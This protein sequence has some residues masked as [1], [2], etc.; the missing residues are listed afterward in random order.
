MKMKKILAMILCVAMVLSTIGTVAFAEEADVWGGTSYSLEW[1]STGDPEKT[2][3]DKFYLNSAEDLA[4]LAYYVNT[5]ASTNNIFTGDTVYLNVDVDLDNHDWA[6][7]GTA[8][9]R[10]KNRF[11]GSFDGQGHTISNLK[12]GEGHYYAGLFGQI[13]TYDYTQTF[14]NITIENA[15]V[16]AE[17]ETETGKNKE[18]AGTLI[19]RANGTIVENCHVTGEINI[20]GDRFVGGLIGHSYAQIS[21]CSVESSGTISADTWQAGGLV[22]S[23]GATATYTSSIKN[24]SVIGNGDD[25]LSVTSYYKSVGGVIGSVSLTDV[26]STPMDGITVANVSVAADSEDYGSGIAYVAVGYAATNSTTD[27]VSA[28]LGNEEYVADDADNVEAAVAKI[29]N[30]YYATLK[31][32]IDSAVA[33]DTIYL[34]G[35]INEGAIKLPATITNLTIDGQETAVVKDTTIN[36][37]DGNSVNYQG[38]TIKNTTFDNSRFVL[39]GVRNGDVI[40]K[41][42]VFDNN[43]FINI[44]NTAS[45]AAIHMNLASED[46]EYIENFTFTNN[47]IDGVT[48]SNN[49]GV[50]LKSITGNVLFEGNTVSNVAWNAIQ[51]ATA[52]ADANLVI[53]NNSFTSSGSSVLNIA[54]APKATL[55]NNTVVNESGKTGIY[56]PA[57]AKT[58]NTYYKTLEEALKAITNE[59]NVVDILDTI[60]IDYKWDNRNTGA[61]ITVPVTING[62]DNIIKVTGEISDGFNYLSVFRFEDDATVRDLT[63]DLSEAIS[64]WSPRLRAISAKGNLTVD[65]CTFIGNK[66]YTNTRAIIFGESGSAPF[67]ADAQISIT[68][69]EFIDWRKGITDNENAKD[70]KTVTVTGNKFTNASVGISATDTIE[71]NN[72]TVTGGNVTITSYTIPNKLSVVAK[73][74]TLDETLVN[75]IKADAIDADSDF[76]LP[77]ADINGE[78]YWTITEAMDAA[79]KNDVIKITN[80]EDAKINE[81]TKVDDETFKTGET[82]VITTD[83]DEGIEVTVPELVSHVLESYDGTQGTY[84]VVVEHKNTAYNEAAATLDLDISLKHTYDGVTKDVDVADGTTFTVK[85]KLPENA[86]TTKPITILH[87]GE[88]ITEYKIE[89]KCVVFETDGFSPF[90]IGYQLLSVN[91]PATMC[92]KAEVK[93]VVSEENENNT[94]YDIV[95]KSTDTKDI[96]GLVSA[97]MDITAAEMSGVNFLVEGANDFI[98]TNDADSYLFTLKS[99]SNQALADTKSGESVT[100]GKLTISGFT[101]DP[102]KWTVG[103]YTVNSVINTDDGAATSYLDTNVTP[104][105][106][107]NIHIALTGGSVT[108]EKDVPKQ[109]LTVE[110]TF[111]KAIEDNDFN[112]QD[113][114]ITVSEQDYGIVKEFVLGKNH[115]DNATITDD[116]YTVSVNLPK[117]KTYTV[118]IE[119]AGYRTFTKTVDLDADK[120]MIVWNNYKDNGALII[121]DGETEPEAK[122][123]IT[124]LAGDIVKDNTVNAYDLSVLLSYAF[125]EGINTNA[126]SKYAQYDLNRDGLINYKDAAMILDAKVWGK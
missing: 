28:T 95:I 62:N 45:M 31:A 65:N 70:V 29:D 39:G 51:I 126:A 13:P 109:E 98:V 8:V 80:N 117:Y 22:G 52:K 113:M 46:N 55:E 18:A 94:V 81:I 34:I 14:S 107:K 74:N 125:T 71:F 25:G 30:K 67:E 79:E 111:P 23:H 41:D 40:Y 116:K 26:D 77:A 48:G 10:E 122:A 91:A 58:G 63:I 36:A 92:E 24:C 32:A 86:D 88:L 33:G 17:N 124:F 3:G 82:E 6:P 57:K 9:P 78:K 53:K 7:I 112:Y 104:N 97:Q 64:G 37:I 20:S 120:T 2:A 50:V 5:Y 85:V 12:V 68:N 44:V 73:G 38:L 76:V 75:S 100:V 102:I 90:T 106:T 1:L 47:V 19:G 4:G 15:V 56:F 103:T 16:V 54:A 105:E 60:T 99:A 27:N 21:D 59:N 121:K 115:A 89:D 35:T 123:T 72:N 87:D 69:S 96:F 110:V 119:G 61:K 84:E 101:T 42:I 11:Y 43:K 83:I 93:F 49:S 108:Y 118:K 66:A 114:K